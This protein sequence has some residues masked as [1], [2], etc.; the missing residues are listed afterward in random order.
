MFTVFVVATVFMT[1]VLLLKAFLDQRFATLPNVVFVMTVVNFCLYLCNWSTMFVV[2]C[3]DAT[4]LVVLEVELAF[5][6]Y[7]FI[8]KT[9][10]SEDSRLIFKTITCMGRPLIKLTTLLSL[11]CLAGFIAENVYT[12]GSLF[13]DDSA[14]HTESMPLVGPIIRALMPI[15]FSVSLLEMIDGRNSKSSTFLFVLLVVYSLI[16]S[17]GRFWFMVSVICA[18]FV[19]SAYKR[20]LIRN[21][22]LRYKLFVVAAVVVLMNVMFGFG[23]ERMAQDFSFY[24]GYNGPFS[25]FEPVAWYY[26]YFPYSFYNLN[27]TLAHIDFNSSF[28]NGA[29]LL[30]PFLSFLQLDGAFGLSYTDL[31]LSTRVI[32][33]S[34]ATVAT[35]YYEMYADFGPLMFVTLFVYLA[36]TLH[37]ERKQG[38]GALVS[39][40]YMWTVWL[41]MSFL[42]IFTVGIPLYVFLFGWLIGRF[43]VERAH[44][45]GMRSATPSRP[46]PFERGR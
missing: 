34:A 36:I 19:L 15:S 40:R 33:N 41:F 17:K 46:S 28:T 6:V 23:V 2:P 31:T 44:G 3:S 11:V 38:F 35:G 43:G 29:F 13:A 4:Y 12:H 5:T 1:G 39:S 24:T 37:F 22:P 16:G 42:N 32:T 18:V 30:L 7:A 25:D 20:D 10:Y 8:P 21:I 9:D 26:G 27:L 14:Y 45:G